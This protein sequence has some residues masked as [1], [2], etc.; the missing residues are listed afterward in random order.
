MATT[1][2]I[3]A[4]KAFVIIEALDKTGSVLRAVHKRM[5]SFANDMTSLGKGLLVK[6][7]AGLLPVG[8]S[9]RTFSNFDD[10][11]RKVEARSSGTAEEMKALRHQAKELGRT[12]SFTAGQI[13]ELQAKLAQKGFN[14]A[15]LQQMTPAVQ[16]LARGAG[17]GTEEDTTLAADLVS[18]TLRSFQLGADQSTRVADVMTAAVNNSNFTLQAL[19]DSMKYA[20]PVAQQFNLGL[21]ETVATLA[22]M[23][24]VNLD[25]STA[26]TAFR[27]MLLE[28]SDAGKRTKF[29]SALQK[30]TGQTIDMVD[31]SSG[32]LK[33]LPDILFAIGE[34]T[35]DLGS[36]KKGELFNMIF[37]KRAIVPS[38]VLGSSANPF[39]DLLTV[40]NNSQGV[41]RKTAVQMDAGLGGA[42][43]LLMSAV[44]GVAIAIGEALS[45][46]LVNLAGIIGNIL[47]DVAKW[48]EQNQG[49]VVSV[50]AAIATVVGLGAGLI[51]LGAAIHLVAFGF[52]GLA[53]VASVA[54]GAVG[55]LMAPVVLVGASI[56][57]AGAAVWTFRDRIMAGLAA[58]PSLFRGFAERLVGTV[59]TAFYEA[60]AI[61]AGLWSGLVDSLGSIWAG[62]LGVLQAGWG[63]VTSWLTGA[64]GG[65]AASVGGLF[66]ALF[67]DVFG[68]G[69][70]IAS[71]VFRGL[72]DA[73]L[74]VWSMF[75]MA[76][77]AAWQGAVAVIGGTLGEIAGMV[78]RAAGLWLAIV[79]PIWN[80][81]STALL[82]AMTMAMHAVGAV[83]SGLVA[84]LQASWDVFVSHLLAQWGNTVGWF[85]RTWQ[86]IRSAVAGFASGV[87]ATFASIGSTIAGV[88]SGIGSSAAGTWEWIRQA[89]G[90]VL[91]GI[92][93]YLG[94]IPAAFQDTFGAMAAFVSE[95]FG[96]IG[97]TI[98]ETFGA[99]IQAL[100]SGDFESAWSIITDGLSLAWSQ[101]V[102]TLADAWD[103]FTG[104]FVEAWTGATKAVKELWLSA[105]KTIATGLLDLAAEDGILGDI[106]DKVLGVDVSEEKKR[107]VELERKRLESAARLGIDTT[108]QAD[109]FQQARD[110]MREQFDQ[111]I[112]SVGDTAGR[113]LSDRDQAIR[114]ADRQR[115]EELLKRR[116]ALSKRLDDVTTRR[117]MDEAHARSEAVL[118]IGVADQAKMGTAARQAEDLTNEIATAAPVAPRISQGLE[119]GTA[120]AMQAFQE[121]RFANSE[122]AKMLDEATKQTGFLKDIAENTSGDDDD[123]EGV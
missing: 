90:T 1:G 59:G 64:V 39:G 6:G 26:G 49:M 32:N 92:V 86:A 94:S 121:N 31:Q 82:G 112:A 77:G 61:A 83:W 18:G 40:L 54:A 36:A 103:S 81:I 84:V 22:Q 52:S 73:L 91:G 100:T 13:G 8:L 19:I 123:F 45:P 98:S 33:P 122:L 114:E 87:V 7:F 17:E 96:A 68:R 24:N 93:S 69:S 60:T 14:R 106:L 42:Y 115:E 105:Q 53:S 70:G 10:A 28:L 116:E 35:R 30:E 80:A 99:A 76:V 5:R 74:G 41:A 4:G 3:K 66:S 56:V 55:L 23:T 20:A 29:L 97:S 104:F 101:M 37:G 119:H 118:G 109:A 63:G 120:E 34:A 107:G 46:S 25:A 27:N 48:I 11:L 58:I 79:R 111:R 65:L 44:E 113:R 21:E 110:A 85:V 15:Q 67:A 88:F 71:G 72:L 43:R 102:D 95:R 2:G 12:T 9:L 51:G 108:P 78:Q 57:A 89:A 50:T 38:L 117:K 62:L 75:T 16:D 47:P